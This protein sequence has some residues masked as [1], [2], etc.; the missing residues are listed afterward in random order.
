MERNVV[1][2]LRASRIRRT[3]VRAVPHA[4]GQGGDRQRQQGGC[5]VKNMLGRINYGF[6]LLDTIP[7]LDRLSM[8]LIRRDLLGQKS[9]R[10]NEKRP[11]GS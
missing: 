6:F 11:Q 10:I 4:L 8:M 2:V 5:L 7:K 1:D 9:S 3:A